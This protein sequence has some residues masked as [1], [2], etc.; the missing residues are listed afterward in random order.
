MDV[1]EEILKAAARLYCEAG[2]R[3]TTTRGV[4]REA[5]VNEVTVFRHFGSKEAL[6]R[7]A[8]GRQWGGGG[9][10]PFALESRGDPHAELQDWAGRLTK[11]LREMAPLIRTRLGEF[12]EHPEIVPPRR[13]RRPRRSSRD[14]WSSCAPRA[15]RAPS[16]MRAPLP[17]C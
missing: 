8:I 1:R 4:A 17:P 7:E 14:T 3:G 6:L 11:G 5:G 16:S 9:C 13:R 15:W 10:S 2:F 12:E